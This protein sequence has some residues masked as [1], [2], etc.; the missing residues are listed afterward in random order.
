MVSFFAP[1]TIKVSKRKPM[2][3]FDISPAPNDTLK[4]RIGIALIVSV[5]AHLLL[6]GGAGLWARHAAPVIAETSPDAAQVTLIEADEK[7]P[8]VPPTDTPAFAPVPS[9]TPIPAQ[10]P[11]PAPTQS[12]VA[13]PT[14]LPTPNTPISSFANAP[15]SFPYATPTAPS[16]TPTPQPP[17]PFAPTPPVAAV[18]LKPLGFTR[19]AQIVALQNPDLTAN[20]RTGDKKISLRVRLD[21]DATGAVS[22]VTLQS[23]SG[24]PEI[25]KRATDTL[26][27]AKF[28]PALVNGTPTASTYPF[29]FT[30]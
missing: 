24:N 4:P 28:I 29:T 8:P 11:R 20:L 17:T 19:A 7:T 9:P 1:G 5:A 2:T 14:P 16:A 21:V 10:T 26:M 12:P 27:R 15:V 3:A 6:L 13:A 30:F 18:A 25:D 23:S 22:G